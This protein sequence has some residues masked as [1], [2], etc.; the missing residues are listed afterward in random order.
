MKAGCLVKICGITNIEDAELAAGEGADY[1]GVVIEV[2]YSPRSQTVESAEPIFANTSIP[3]VALVHEMQ[4]GRLTEL[5]TRLKPFAVQFLS[6]DGAA[7]AGQL[8]KIA[9]GMEIWQSLFIP[10]AGDS[11][12]MFDPGAVLR[13]VEQC[14][15]AGVDAVVL[16]TAAVINGVVRFGGTG[17]TGQWD[18]AARIVAGSTLPAFLAGGIKPENVREA[19]ESVRPYGIDLCSGVESHKGKKSPA[20]LRSLMEEAQKAGGMNRR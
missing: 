16:D 15:K 18:Q 9:P 14:Q 20:K 2:S 17:T 5:V 3:A 4:P 8:K 12:S 7:M 13:Q 19:V 10:A 1:I 11:A 6:R